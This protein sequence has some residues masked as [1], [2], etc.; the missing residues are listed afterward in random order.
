MAAR[1]QSTI[2]KCKLERQSNATFSTIKRSAQI[3]QGTIYCIYCCVEQL[4][5]NRE[6]YTAPFPIGQIHRRLAW[7]STCNPTN[8]RVS[9]LKGLC[10]SNPSIQ[11]ASFKVTHGHK[12]IL[13]NKIRIGTVQM[14]PNK[15]WPDHKRVCLE[16]CASF[17]QLGQVLSSQKKYIMNSI[18]F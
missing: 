7:E 10:L 6:I 13:Q 8:A 4:H 17:R 15:R 14:L 12:E 3:I 9:S 1:N 18:R 16:S 5:M 2:I 11:Y